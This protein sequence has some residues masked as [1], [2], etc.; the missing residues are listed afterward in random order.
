VRIRLR[1]ASSKASFYSYEHV[2]GTML[3][4]LVHNVRGPHDAIF[5]KVLDE[6]K[7]ECEELMAKVGGR[8]GKVGE[9]GKIEMGA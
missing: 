1:R 4:E 8:R 3:H 6:I 7:A 9:E 5:Y 2:L